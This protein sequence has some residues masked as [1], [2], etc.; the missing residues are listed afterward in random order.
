MDPRDD[1]LGTSAN[2]P[3][4]LE[5]L[6]VLVVIAMLLLTCGCMACWGLADFIRPYVGAILE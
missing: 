2:S 3:R 6:A 1:S 4:S 5:R